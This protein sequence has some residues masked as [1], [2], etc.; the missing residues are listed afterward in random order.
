MT[1][2]VKS[3]DFKTYLTETKGLERDFLKELITSKKR[4][5]RVSYIMFTLSLLALGAGIAGLSQKAPAPL[6]L[7]VDNATGAVDVVT[8]MREHQSS[9]N[10][11]IDDYW[12]NRYVIDRESYDYNTIQQHYDAVA[13][14]SAPDIQKEYYTKFEGVNALDKTLSN[15]ARIVVHIKSI[16]LN[17]KGQATVRFTTQLVYS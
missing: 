16:Q 14:L 6:I 4:A 5:W 9:Y 2:A 12:I 17:R 15:Q 3:A 8:T 13:L 10:E 11:I 1:K 7:R